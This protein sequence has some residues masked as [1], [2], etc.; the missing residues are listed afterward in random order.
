MTLSYSW[1]TEA[2]LTLTK[3]THAR[4]ASGIPLDDLPR[5]FRDAICICRGVGVRYLWIDA[6]CIFQDKDDLSDWERE[7][8][9]MHKVYSNTFCNIS[10]AAGVGSSSPIL[11]PRP[12]DAL[13]QDEFRIQW[14]NKDQTITTSSY[15]LV[16]PWDWKKNV[17]EAPVN[18]R[19][20]VMQERML[21]PRIIHFADSQMYWECFKKHA[22]EVY[23]CIWPDE[24]A[25]TEPSGTSMIVSD[26]WAKHVPLKD[27]D[28]SVLTSEL[29]L[30][31][32]IAQW[33]LLVDMY[34]D[35]ELTVRTD[36]LV[37]ISAI[38]RRMA[39]YLGDGSYVTGM[40]RQSLEHSLLWMKLS[41]ASE[42]AHAQP[43]SYLAPS[44]SWV[45]V[46]GSVSFHGENIE[47]VWPLDQGNRQFA[48]VED[49]QLEYTPD[50]DVFGA[51]R[52][53]RLR[54]RGVLQRIQLLPGFPHLSDL[55]AAEVGRTNDKWFS[56]DK[57]GY[58]PVING[59]R[60]PGSI[61]LDW[62]P[63]KKYGKKN[64]NGALFC[65]LVYKYVYKY[66]NF[67]RAWTFLVLQ[68]VSGGTFR[69]LGTAELGGEQSEAVALSRHEQEAHF[70]CIEYKNGKHSIWII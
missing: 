48:E 56:E 47:S 53:G 39:T 12:A 30:R 35:C 20:W 11:R 2:P 3:H 37:A 46:E 9:S 29:A 18:R 13:R 15:R 45:S 49:V 50:G 64:H 67:P 59:K 31:K 23:P 57:Y 42:P 36:K 21:S 17:G 7:A 14:L 54:L 68:V 61:S 58:V 22:S 65:I 27:N 44:W 6:L 32:I 51:L 55:R 10:A 5:A 60:V 34:S 38:A 41:P 43:T 66:A 26:D 70:P 24:R 69:R 19:A 33:R 1:G 25:E 8:R 62:D 63:W 4:L 52:S 28:G 40:W 16:D